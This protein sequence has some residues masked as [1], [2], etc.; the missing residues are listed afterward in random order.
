MFLRVVTES[1]T[2]ARMNFKVKN[3]NPPVATAPAIGKPTSDTSVKKSIKCALTLCYI[4]IYQIYQHLMVDTIYI[5][6]YY[7]YNLLGD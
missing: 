4:V 1:V 7:V 5:V 2:P 3:T 6:C